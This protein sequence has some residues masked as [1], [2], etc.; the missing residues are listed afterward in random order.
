MKRL[1]VQ[2]GKSLKIFFSS[3]GHLV[4][5]QNQQNFKFLFSLNTEII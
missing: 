1:P 4:M 2:E 5:K 3:G